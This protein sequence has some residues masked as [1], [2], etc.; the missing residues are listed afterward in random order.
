MAAERPNV[1]EWAALGVW[2]VVAAWM[3]T[4]GDPIGFVKARLGRA[5]EVAG[6]MTGEAY[7]GDGLS[8]A[9]RDITDGG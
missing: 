5:A 1:T 8:D 7:V 6:A 9:L 3:L 2:L 4:K